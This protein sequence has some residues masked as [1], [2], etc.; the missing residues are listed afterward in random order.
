[1]GERT[2]KIELHAGLGTLRTLFTQLPPVAPETMATAYR[3]AFVGP[4][5]L[6]RTAAPALALLGLGGWWGKWF[7]GDG[8]GRNIVHRRGRLQWAMPI[9]VAERPSL[10]DG[11]PCLAVLYP[12]S[13]PFPW[14]YVVDELRRLDEERLLG[15]TIADLPGL[16]RIAFPFLLHAQPIDANAALQ[17]LPSSTSQPGA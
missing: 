4:W 12:H 16:R 5:W 1:M 11:Q 13:S 9:T 14:R 7:D 17:A 2:N 15:L 10:I 8:N 6:R 3:A